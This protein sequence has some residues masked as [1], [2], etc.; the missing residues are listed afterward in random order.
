[1]NTRPRRE[2]RD[3]VKFVQDNESDIEL[4]D[5]SED[6]YVPSKSDT[7][8]ITDS[9]TENESSSD[10][11]PLIMLGRKKTKQSCC[12]KK[13]SKEIKQKVKANNV[14]SEQNQNVEESDE[15]DDN[16][17]L[18]HLTNA[19]I[20]ND[21]DLQNALSNIEQTWESKEF[22][23]E[24]I[25]YAFKGE[26]EEPPADANIES[27]YHYFKNMITD[28]M[29]AQLKYQ[30]NLYVLQK[31]GIELN[32]TKKEIEIFIGIYIRMGLVSMPR[33]RAY[34]ESSSRYPSIAD[35]M[36]RNRFEKLAS[37]IHISNN[38]TA[39]DKEK[40]DKLWKIRPWLSAL[41][42]QFLKIPAEEFNSVDEI[43]VAFK[44]KSSLKQYIRGKP[45][46]WGFKLWGR[47]GASGVLYDFNVY[48]GKAG[49]KQKI[50]SALE[51][52]L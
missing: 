1:M 42:S 10:D 48:Q 43:M 44:G 51:G 15:S 18:A 31:D 3:I 26:E 7:E 20:A 35:K 2:V 49:G 33:V 52:M 27:P 38:L 11:E 17:P 16:V 34:W 8:N 30:T 37:S 19:D 21:P 4:Q 14:L 12:N 50:L 29:I 24:N 22:D 9:N 41:R 32:T 13:T 28:D 47:A 5:S 39:T 23:A 45:N 46:P 36:S 40:E 25:D 6:E